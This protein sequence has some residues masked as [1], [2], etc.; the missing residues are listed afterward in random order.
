M[1]N[2]YF[3][4]N[5]AKERPAFSSL[6]IITGVLLLG[7]VLGNILGVLIMMPLIGIDIE[8]AGNVFQAIVESSNGWLAMMLSQGIASVARFIISG[9]FYW[10]LIEKKKFSDFHFRDLPAPVLFIIIFAIQLS[11]LPFNGWLQSMNENLQF[12]SFLKAL[13]DFLKPK[14]GN[15]AEIMKIMTTFDSAG[16]LILALLVIA[17]VAGIGEELIFRGLIQ[18][19][20]QLAF[21]NHH[22]AIWITAIIFSAF[23][24]QFNDFFPRIVLGAMMGYFYYWS[25]N[26]WVPV[27]AHIFNN[28][29][30]VIMLYLINTKRVSPEIEKIENVPVS[31]ILTSVAMSIGFIYLLWKNTSVEKS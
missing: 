26:F 31:V 17:I 18:R 6:L 3:V 12:P 15:L 27:A 29:F 22:A 5:P 8:D 24:M 25:G 11:L 1:E 23:H 13:E 19:K 30:A 7:M 16:Q 28:A 2:T 4:V 14:E 9:L 10:Y 20:L 21:K